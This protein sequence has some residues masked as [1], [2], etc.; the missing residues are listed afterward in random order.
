MPT[1]A[2]TDASKTRTHTHKPFG[3]PQST[4]AH[5]ASHHCPGICH[6]NPARVVDGGERLLSHVYSIGTQ[7]DGLRE[8]ALGGGKIGTTKRGIGPAYATKAYRSGMRV[9]DLYNEDIFV[10][11]MTRL[12]SDAKAA[13]PSFSGDL[14]SELAKCVPSPL[15][16]CQGG[17][18]FGDDLE[19]TARDIQSETPAK[20]RCL[21]ESECSAREHHN[22]SCGGHR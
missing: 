10:E 1:D 19:E 13:H 17:L 21:H 7:V 18:F 8:E 4:S 14:E 2:P 15:P 20:K 22:C 3:V 11:R 6:S 9:C 5:K 16:I 12:F